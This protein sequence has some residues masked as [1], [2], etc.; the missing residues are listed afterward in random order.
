MAL[1]PREFSSSHETW[2][3]LDGSCELRTRYQSIVIA[4]AR[5]DLTPKPHAPPFL[6]V[7]VAIGFDAT[8]ATGI[9]TMSIP[10]T[11]ETEIP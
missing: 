4:Q 3:A 9:V 5:L 6:R 1:G 8:D 11:S 7:L 10:A 2:T